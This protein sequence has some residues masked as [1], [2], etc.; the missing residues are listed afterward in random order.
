MTM[1]QQNG[2]YL[3]SSQYDRMVN[4]LKER[5]EKVSELE[6]A[7]A[8]KDQEISEIQETFEKQEQQLVG[9]HFDDCLIIFRKKRKRP[10]ERLKKHSM[11]LSI[12]LK[13]RKLL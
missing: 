5:T 1:R 4:T 11:R 7:L 8:T 6:I 10:L 12:S 9:E 2:V 13:R 3:P